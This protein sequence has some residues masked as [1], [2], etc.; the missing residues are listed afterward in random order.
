MELELINQA[1][2]TEIPKSPCIPSHQREGKELDDLYSV[3]C[4]AL[5]RSR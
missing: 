4:C 3:A 5:S 2:P 1:P